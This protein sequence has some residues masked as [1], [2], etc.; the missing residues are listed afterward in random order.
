MR[1]VID[2]NILV[3]ILISAHGS[4]QELLFSGEVEVIAPDRL[5]FEVGKHWKEIC[6]KSKLSEEDL[7]SSLSLVREEIKVFPL[8]TYR[9]KL[10]ESKDMCPHLKD[11]EY[12][13]LAL[14]FNCPIWSEEKR[15]KEQPSVEVLSTKELLKRLGLISGNSDNSSRA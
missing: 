14:K 13:A 10:S 9:D 15:L 1:A 8:N 3:S 4:K 6:D 5:L 12:F 11:A 7:E 2:A